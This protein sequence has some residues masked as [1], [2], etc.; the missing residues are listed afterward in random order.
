MHLENVPVDWRIYFAALVLL[1]GI[2][3]T[4]PRQSVCMTLWEMSRI[5]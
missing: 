5:I 1:D 3:T 4:V 2:F